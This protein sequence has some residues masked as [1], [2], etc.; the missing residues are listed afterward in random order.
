M[1]VARYLDRTCRAAWQPRDVLAIRRASSFVS[2]FACLASG[3]SRALG[4]QR[5]EPT[6]VF[7]M[8][9]TAPDGA[10][11]V[12]AFDAIEAGGWM[13]DRDTFHDH[14]VRAEHGE[15]TN[16]QQGKVAA[17][18]KKTKALD[19]DDSELRRRFMELSARRTL[20]ATM[21]DVPMADTWCLQRAEQCARLARVAG[22]ALLRAELETEARLWLQIAGSE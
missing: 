15:A 22:D 8:E 19:L 4:S 16:A 3:R 2:T 6:Q 20:S 1:A 11:I 7:G 13:R 12:K 10:S 18:R 21:V 5:V 14:A 17:D 9:Q